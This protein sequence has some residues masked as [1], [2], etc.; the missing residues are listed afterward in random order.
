MPKRARLHPS[1]E[2]EDHEAFVKL[3]KEIEVT[4]SWLARRAIKLFLDRYRKNPY[5][6]KLDLEMPK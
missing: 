6:L 3:A 4:P 5:Q 1:L 2:S